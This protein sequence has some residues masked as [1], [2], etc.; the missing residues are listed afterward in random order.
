LAADVRKV[1]ND[2]Y[3]YRLEYSK[4]QQAGDTAD[5]TPYKPILGRSADA[6]AAWLAAAAIQEGRSF[7]AYGKIE[8][9]PPSSQA[10][11]PR[12]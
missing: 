5:S 10:R 11:W 1:G 9:A 2:G 4:T 6:L 3:I 8:W 12:S 7:G